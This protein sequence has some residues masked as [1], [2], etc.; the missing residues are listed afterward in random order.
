MQFNKERSIH[1]MVNFLWK[2]RIMRTKTHKEINNNSKKKLETIH[3][4]SLSS[5]SS[6]RK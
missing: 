5:R 3:E 6:Q 1:C 2:A 4:K